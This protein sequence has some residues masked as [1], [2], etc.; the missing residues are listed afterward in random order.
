MN[1]KRGIVMLTTVVVAATAAALPRQQRPQGPTRRTAQQDSA[2]ARLRRLMREKVDRVQ[3]VFRALAQGDLVGVRRGADDLARIAA[4]ADWSLG[5]PAG[6][7]A[8][9]HEAAFRQRTALLAKFARQANRK[10]AYSHFVQ[11]ILQCFDCHDELRP[12]GVPPP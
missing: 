11:F 6:P 1:R 2:R 7:E 9:A 10:A 4:Q 5:P 8:A 3:F 12:V